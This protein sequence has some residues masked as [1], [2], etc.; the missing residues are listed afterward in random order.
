MNKDINNI[1]KEIIEYIE[2]DEEKMVFWNNKIRKFLCQKCLG[3][4]T[5]DLKCEHCSIDFQ[6]RNSMQFYSHIVDF[7]NEEEYL[8]STT[9]SYFDVVDNKPIL[10]GVKSDTIYM[11]NDKKRRELSFEYIYEIDENGIY[12]H[13]KEEQ[14]YNA[15]SDG[16]LDEYYIYC[17]LP[18]YNIFKN[19]VHLY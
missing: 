8:S 10:Y 7:K 15:K 17:Y 14:V 1:P 13:V 9:Y 18:R 2:K 16:Y 3:E 19:R 6:F 5:K 12:D 4:L 11:N